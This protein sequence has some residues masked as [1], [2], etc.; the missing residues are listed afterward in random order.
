VSTTNSKLSE[1]TPL[2]QDIRDPHI[3]DYMTVVARHKRIVI[4]SCLFFGLGLFGI[5][6][7]MPQTFTSELTLLPPEKQGVAGGL[8]SFL[9]GSSA[10]DM[11]KS[12]EN[13]ALDLFKNILDSRMLSEEIADDKR[14]RGYFASFDS[15]HDGA[16]FMARSS[17]TSEPLRNGIMTVDVDLKTHW[18]ASNAEI[19]SAKQI[20]AYLANL[21]VDRL[22]HFNRERLTTVA[23][24]TRVFVEMEYQVRVGQLDSVYHA[25]QAFQESNKTIALPEQLTS[26]V[27]AAA[28][29]SAEIQQLEIQLGV[30]AREMNPNSNRMELLKAQIQEAK[31]ALKKYDDGSVG[32]YVVGLHSVPE[33]SR[34]VAQFTR[35]IK[36][37][38]QVNGYLRQELEQ[39]KINEQKDLPS[40]QVLDRATPPFRKSSPHRLSMLLLGVF[41]GVLYSLAHI[42]VLSYA[43]HVRENPE[44]HAKFLNFTRALG[45]GKRRQPQSGTSKG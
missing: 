39:E 16:A 25:Y 9:A 30:E 35:E 36:L 22:D 31:D 42:G 44:E 34:R 14:V 20:S 15:S 29:L 41:I 28:R 17:M 37:L 8:M 24:N 33:L 3:L 4:I 12:Q 13:P 21:Y 18:N 10:L 5:T 45:F 2:V 7:F 38:E 19:D 11:M 40:L 32:E 1:D 26:T 43:E 6:L 23:H 27:T